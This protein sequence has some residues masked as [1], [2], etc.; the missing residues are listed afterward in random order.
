MLELGIE[1]KKKLK[2]KALNLAGLG[3]EFET[4]YKFALFIPRWNVT[5]RSM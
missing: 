3:Q 1:G 2:C 5:G 4:S